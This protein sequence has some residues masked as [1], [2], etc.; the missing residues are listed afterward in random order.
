MSTIC[1][2]GVVMNKEKVFKI[3]KYITAVFSFV[4]FICFIVQLSRIYFSSLKPLYS[5]DLVIGYLLQILPVIIIHILVIIIA[6]IFSLLVKEQK[7]YYVKTTNEAKLK[8]LERRFNDNCSN[9]TNY[10]SLMK[11]HNK[12][13]IAIVIS[14][15]LYLIC[16]IMTSLYLFN[17]NHFIYNGDIN[18]QIIDMLI[19]ISPWLV[20]ALLTLI[21]YTYY[22]NYLAKIGLSYAKSILKEEGISK[23]IKF[24]K[25]AHEKLILNIVRLSII[26]I[27]VTL[28]IIGVVA[29]EP[30][31]VYQKAINICT[32]C[33][34]LG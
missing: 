4:M 3:I 31:R 5:R 25:I 26:V 28:I 2:L 27:A 34:G 19:H 7:D 1:I 10:K 17:P 13:K 15:L 16:L 6:F 30:Q 20:I 22:I 12:K 11:I 33:I 14:L 21:I 32:E 8:I 29:G 9:N 24:K 18:G 23:S